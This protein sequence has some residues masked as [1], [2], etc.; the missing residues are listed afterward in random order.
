M[1]KKIFIAIVLALGLTSCVESGTPE[2]PFQIESKILSDGRVIDCIDT[3]RRLSC[4]WDSVRSE[5]E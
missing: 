5:K 3:G 2:K 4:D 1:I